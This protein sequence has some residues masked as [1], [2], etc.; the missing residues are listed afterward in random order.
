MPTSALDWAVKDGS[1]RR[2]SVNSFGYGGAN[3]HV[4]LEQY[5]QGSAP[6][7][8][9]VHEA[10]ERPY[11]LPISS[12]SQQAGDMALQKHAD[13]LLARVHMGTIVRDL[14]YSL[15]TRRSLHAFRTFAVGSDPLELGATLSGAIA[16]RTW[17]SPL[18]SPV[19]VGFVFTGQGAQVF[20]MGR[21]LLQLSP[22]FRRTLARCDETL[23]QLPD[24]PDWC[25]VV[26]LLRPEEDSR[27]GQSKYSQPICTA[28]QLALVNLLADWGVQP[29]AVCGHSSGEIA[30]AYSAGILSLEGAIVA[31]YYRGLHMASGLGK[32]AISGAMMAAGLSQA[33]AEVELAPYAGRL[34]VAAVNSPSS[35]TISGDAGAIAELLKSL[36][37][38]KIF[39]RQLKVEQA[40]HSHHMLPMAPRYQA[41]LDECGLVSP[42]DAT[43]RMFSSVTARVAEPRSMGAAYWAEN[44][45]KPSG[46]PTP[47]SAC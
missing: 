31:A 45:V 18:S 27:L 32:G 25:I 9:G 23:Q 4:V 1:P 20:D 35:V 38:R 39:A 24:K 17:T 42:R 26:E 40:F 7:I 44:M 30:A 33:E 19:R 13:Y 5:L 6:L 21:Q 8:N 12:H 47:S 34:N 15:G 28:L 41:A 11:L 16:K 2:A 3:A 36:S 22:G 14:A 29:A 43:C 10:Q 37:A 46:S